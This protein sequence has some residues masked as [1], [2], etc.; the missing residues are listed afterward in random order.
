MRPFLQNIFFFLKPE[1]KTIEH[2]RTLR[3]K[4][5]LKFNNK[6]VFA[7]Y[8]DA[9]QFKA[10]TSNLNAEVKLKSISTSILND[11]KMMNGF[12]LKLKFDVREKA[13]AKAKQ[14]MDD[15]FIGAFDRIVVLQ[16]KADEMRKETT[17]ER[18]A[19]SVEQKKQFSAKNL[20]R[21]LSI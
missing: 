10:I 13:L 21:R 12:G 1:L 7:N 2:V 18:Q 14:E 19:M 16:E 15:F 8:V 20:S 5:A 3:E 4:V 17:N 6:I 9:D 11:L